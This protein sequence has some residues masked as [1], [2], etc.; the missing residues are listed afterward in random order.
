M[1]KK[2]YNALDHRAVEYDSDFDDFNSSIADLHSQV[3]SFMDQQFDRF[4]STPRSVL[5]L[6]KFEK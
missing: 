6:R 4:Q 5:L 1:R 2:P 3:I